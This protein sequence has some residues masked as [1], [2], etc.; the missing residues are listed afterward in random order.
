MHLAFQG[1]FNGLKLKKRD[2][3]EI[4]DPAFVN[5][6][7]ENMSGTYEW[8]NV[9]FSFAFSIRWRRQCVKAANLL[10]G[11]HVVDL[12]SGMGEA[13]K[14]ILYYTKNDCRITGVDFCK[15][16]IRFA[17]KEK[18]K[19]GHTN[20]S[21]L[22]EN[23]LEN[24]L[25]CESVDAV[26]STFGLKTFSEKQIELLATEMMWLLKPGGVCSI[27]EISVPKRPVLKWPYLYYLKY[28]IPLLG[29][30]FLGNPENYRML[31]IYTERF[32]D[33]S[34]IEDIFIETGFNTVL[35]EYFFGCATGIIGKK[36][37]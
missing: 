27:L 18:L 1:F 31:G 3:Q 10:P 15:G 7:F 30:I 14:P 9:I 4:Y 17:E 6:L 28:A 34:G 33:C 37:I 8:M 20:I 32:G 29:R 13:W 23:A 5:Q 11:M 35:K 16:M 12:M 24:S 2:S 21:I 22:C 19:L 36:P 25:P 26:I